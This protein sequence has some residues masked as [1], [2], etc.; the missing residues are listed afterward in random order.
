MGSSSPSIGLLLDASRGYAKARTSRRSDTA[1]SPGRA[2]AGAVAALFGYKPRSHLPSL[3]VV[4]PWTHD[5]LVSELLSRI[6]DRQGSVPPLSDAAGHDEV[7]GHGTG[8]GLREHLDTLG[9][10]LE[11]GPSDDGGWSIRARIP[12]R[13]DDGRRIRLRI[14][15]GVPWGQARDCPIQG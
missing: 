5:R 9:G 12:I 2:K 14:I 8:N 1:S 10:Q 6:L 15:P 4:A 7:C 3:Q 11:A 13:L